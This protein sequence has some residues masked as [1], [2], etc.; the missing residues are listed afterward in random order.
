[1]RPGKHNKIRED[2]ENVSPLLPQAMARPCSPDGRRSYTERYPAWRT[3]H[4]D[5]V[6]WLFIPPLKDFCKCDMK[7]ADIYTNS[8]ETAAD[9]R[10]H[11]RWIVRNGIRK[12]EHS[13][14]VQLAEKRDQRKQRSAKPAPSQPT[15]FTCSKCGRDR[16]AIMGLL[17]HT[18]RC[19]QQN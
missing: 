5:A 9:D 4:W 13:R 17:S 7:M 15:T 2:T 3:C 19:A 10:F 1:M 6:Y 12:A 18:R 11:L 14:Y 8:W 16:H